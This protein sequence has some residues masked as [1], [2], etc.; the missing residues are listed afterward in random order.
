MQIQAHSAVEIHY[1][2]KNVG[3]DILDSSEGGDPLP[4]IHGVGAL[5]PGLER[6]LEGK[7]AGEKVEVSLQPVD[8]YGERS[9][10]LMQQVPREAFQFD[11]EIQVGMR[12][13]AETEHGVELVTIT[14]LDDMHVTVDA[15][16]SLAGEVL[17]FDVNVVSVREA[18]PDELSHG[19]VHNGNCGHSH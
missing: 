16:H 6:A 9:D 2:L 10:T 15:N 5:V 3:G 14:A 17:N 8:G 11:G 18:T 13:E 12:F 4:Y 19:H 7:G 1:T